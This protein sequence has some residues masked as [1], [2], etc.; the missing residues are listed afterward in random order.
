MKSVYDELAEKEQALLMAAQ[1]GKN[2]IDEKEDLERQIEM[3]KREHQLQLEVRD[4]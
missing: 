2:L 3:L 4:K 1:F